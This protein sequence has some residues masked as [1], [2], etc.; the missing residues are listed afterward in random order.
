[1][2]DLEILDLH[3]DYTVA[4][5]KKAFRK[6]SKKLHPDV[7]SDSISSHLAMIQLNKAYSRLLSRN[8]VIPVADSV[9]SKDSFSVY[10]QGVD[11]F[12]KVHPS[13]WKKVTL[14]DLFCNG[15][16]KASS[17]T[18][19]IIKDLINALSKSYYCF[20]K[21]VHE[22]QDSPWID[23]AYDKMQQIEK[24]TVRYAKILQSYS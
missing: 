22:Y 5:L 21:L 17:N 2:T 7:N 10:K 14:N 18:G 15:G 8:K 1:M 12:Q 13:Q 11:L 20:S 16:I 24:M 9:Q 4:D 6:K 23:D 3:A 19:S